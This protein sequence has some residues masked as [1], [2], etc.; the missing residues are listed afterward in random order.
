MEDG[1]PEA[2]WYQDPEGSDGLLRYWSGTEWTEDRYDPAGATTAGADPT[3]EEST[4]AAEPT[5]E[6]ST[7]AAEPTAGE[8][9][10]AAVAGSSAEPAGDPDPSLNGDPALGEQSG[11]PSDLDPATAPDLA[12]GSPSNPLPGTEWGSAAKPAPDEELTRELAPEAGYA[13]HPT[14]PQPALDPHPPGDGEPSST[15]GTPAGR[16]D[17][18]KV[19]ES[20]G[21]PGGESS[22][23][24][25]GSSSAPAVAAMAA[26]SPPSASPAADS[27]PSDPSPASPADAGLDRA[28]E[29]PGRAG[30]A[31]GQAGEAAPSEG[32]PAAA[33]RRRSAG[34][35]SSQLR[36]PIDS[37]REVVEREPRGIALGAALTAI[38]LVAIGLIVGAGGG[39][40][41]VAAGPGS[42]GQASAGA[43]TSPRGGEGS[44]G[45]GA[46]SGS[47]AGSDGEAATQL[48]TA[49]TAIETYATDNAGEYS[50]AN[51]RK[52]EA[53]ESSLVGANISVDSAEADGYVIAAGGD[54]VSYTITRD[55]GDSART[56]APPGEGECSSDGTW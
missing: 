50:G 4:T 20:F 43:P 18:G 39:D 2:G 37:L 14:E 9:S 12:S 34:L 27:A 45:G 48:L 49:Q 30:E 54:G 52:L 25:Y 28:G 56:C 26:A 10:P 11:P 31:P 44:A 47:G 55:A 21:P 36:G 32:A 13:A 19:R 53:I 29:A 1:A 8:E 51:P 17:S 15:L 22:A 23:S 7:A 40:D 38:V 6:E 3:M 33:K 16:A 46:T 42:S 41:P 5:M 35:G 24:P